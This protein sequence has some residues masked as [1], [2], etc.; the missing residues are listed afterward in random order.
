MNDIKDELE[1]LKF[2][3]ENPDTMRQ[4]EKVIEGIFGKKEDINNEKN[5]EENGD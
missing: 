5:D 3:K 1:R 4:F 2:K